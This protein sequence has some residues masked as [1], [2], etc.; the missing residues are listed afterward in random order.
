MENLIDQNWFFDITTILIPTLFILY[1][2]GHIVFVIGEFKGNTNMIPTVLLL[3][4]FKKVAILILLHQMYDYVFGTHDII[5]INY[6]MYIFSLYIV[7]ESI[8]TNKILRNSDKFQVKLKNFDLNFIKDQTINKALRKNDVH[9]ISNNFLLVRV[10][11]TL[12]FICIIRLTYVLIIFPNTYNIL[13]SLCLVLI[14]YTKFLF[15]RFVNKN[16]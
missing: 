13:F 11:Y 10:V 7:F 4:L 12:L 15:V 2:I 16:Q 6:L 8:L 5:E 9:V 14:I 3:L 1:A